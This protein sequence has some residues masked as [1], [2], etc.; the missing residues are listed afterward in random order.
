M[1]S[2]FWR[3]CFA[4]RPRKVDSA[5]ESTLVCN[6]VMFIYHDGK[7]GLGLEA[8]E[9]CDVF[10]AA[11]VSE[12]NF[13]LT[14]VDDDLTVGLPEGLQVINEHL[15]EESLRRARRTSSVTAAQQRIHV[16]IQRWIRGLGSID[17]DHRLVRGTH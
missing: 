9:G 3:L 5:S 11:G 16:F 17:L 7:G 12:L 13:A 10:I 6:R 8:R 2:H 4:S 1:T 14:K 15:E